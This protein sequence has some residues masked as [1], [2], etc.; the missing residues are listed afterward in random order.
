MCGQ[1]KLAEPQGAGAKPVITPKDILEPMFRKAELKAG[2]KIRFTTN[3]LEASAVQDR[4]P[5]ADSGASSRHGYSIL[6]RETDS[7][8]EDMSRAKRIGRVKRDG[9]FCGISVQ[10]LCESL[11]SRGLNIRISISFKVTP[12]QVLGI[13][14]AEVTLRAPPSWC[15]SMS[16]PLIK[17]EVR[18]GPAPHQTLLNSDIVF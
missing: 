11:Q 5:H 10:S 8:S 16:C 15:Y 3:A 7:I 14:S 2:I 4:V 17:I 9:C 18:S 13:Y 1:P 12:I 6:D